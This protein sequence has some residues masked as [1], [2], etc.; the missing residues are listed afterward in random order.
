MNRRKLGVATFKPVHMV[1]KWM[2]E[3]LKASKRVNE[4]TF[5]LGALLADP[6]IP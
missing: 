3:S 1:A 6:I 2:L 5:T 4:K